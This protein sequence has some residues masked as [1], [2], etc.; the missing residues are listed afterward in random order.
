VRHYLGRIFASI[1]SMVLTLH[2]YDTQCGAKVMRSSS[3]LHD[4]L[5]E[6]FLSRWAFDVELL[7]RLLAGSA[8]VAPVSKDA[9]LEVPLEEWRDVAGTK[10]RLGSMVGATAH[11]LSIGR[12]LQGR[13]QAA[14][15]AG[16]ASQSQSR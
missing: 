5:R 7:G 16:H 6:P 2:V 4:A 14:A 8:D 1:A 11:L 3:A 12:A 9:F 15:R 13:R 10:L